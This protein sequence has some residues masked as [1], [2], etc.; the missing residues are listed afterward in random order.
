MKF[1]ECVKMAGFCSAS[2]ILAIKYYKSLNKRRVQ[3]E[4]IKIFDPLK[5]D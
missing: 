3:G 5:S 1:E 2:H 4:Q